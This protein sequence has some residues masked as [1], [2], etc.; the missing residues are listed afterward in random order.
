M[1]NGSLKDYM[2][3]NR[4][5]LRSMKQ[6]ITAVAILFGAVSYGQVCNVQSE[7]NYGTNENDCKANVSIYTEYLKQS[8]FKK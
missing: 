1:T 7:A 6:I 8:N 5:Q 3:K 4:K 2:N